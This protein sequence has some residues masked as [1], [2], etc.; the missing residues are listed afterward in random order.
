MLLSDCFQQRGDG[1]PSVAARVIQRI[2]AAAPSGYSSA[3]K[4]IL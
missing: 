2:R 3:Q 4:N 1:A